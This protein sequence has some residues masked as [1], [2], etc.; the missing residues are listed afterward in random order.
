MHRA[1]TLVVVAVV[2]TATAA[3]AVFIPAHTEA[4][5]AASFA[6]NDVSV[7]STNGGVERVSAAP[8]FDVSWT[9]ADPT[10]AMF[11]Y[12]VKT[13]DDDSFHRV[14][15]DLVSVNNTGELST[16]FDR[17][18]L[19]ATTNLSIP[20]TE[21]FNVTTPGTE[22][23]TEVTFRVSVRLLGETTD[24]VI[25]EKNISDSFTV[26]VTH[27]GEPTTTPGDPPSS[28]VSVDVTGQAEIDA[29]P[30]GNE[31]RA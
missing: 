27:T 15:L 16:S 31:T 14:G 4:A 17:R 9:N 6:A 7:E 29:R 5:V 3:G 19:F 20:G 24:D 13:G 11:V 23:Q 25:A 26:T 10:Y 18:P 30:A 12:Y 28:D 1:P 21:P 2:L 8:S 22:Q